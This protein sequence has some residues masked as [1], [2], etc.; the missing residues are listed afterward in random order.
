MGAG[1]TLLPIEAI[2]SDLTQALRRVK[3]FILEAPTGSGKSTQVPQ[4]LIDEAVVGPGTVMVLQPRRLAARMLA[5]RVAWERQV[6]LGSEVGYQIR[7]DHQAGSATRITYVTEGILLRRMLENPRLDGVAALLFDEFHER[8]IYSDVTLA[9]AFQIQQQLRPDL[10]LGVMSATLETGRLLEFLAPAACLRA[11]G[12]AWPVTISHSAAAAAVADR[13]IWEQVAWHFQK[14]VREHPEGDV[15]VFL[16]GAFE[17]QRT[18][19][20]IQEAVPPRDWVVLPLHGD[21]PPAQ[22]DAALE[23]YPQRKCVVATNVAETSLTIEGIR[24][25]IDSGLAR[26]AAFD[27]NRGINTLLVEKI[28]RASA[29]QR[30]GRA[31]RTAPGHCLRL[32]GPSDHQHRAAHETPEIRRLD[33]SEIALT[34]KAGGVHDLESFPW[35]EA[36]APSSLSRALGLL[37]E[38]GALSPAGTLTDVGMRMA[39]FPLH[40]RYARMLIEA[41]SRRCVRT[42]AWVAALSQVRSLLLPL[43]DRSRAAAREATLHDPS[44]ESSD[45]FVLLRAW[46][47]AAR[48]NFA[49]DH[50]RQWGIHSVSARQVGYIADQL[51]HLAKSQGLDLDEE[52]VSLDE[53]RRCILLGFSDQLARRLDRATY[54]CQMVHG[55]KGEVRPHSAVTEAPLLV[56]GEVE[57]RDLRGEISVWLSLN[58]A[59]EEAWLEECFPSEMR[60]R[61]AVAFDALQRRVV[62]RR[63]RVFRDLVLE[64]KESDDVPMDDAARILAD[65]VLAGRLILKAWNAEAERWIGRINFAAHHC[66]DYGYHPIGQSERRLILEQVCHGAL[67]YREIKDREVLPTLLD[68]VP[69]NLRP[70]LDSIAPPAISLPRGQKARLRYEAD[71]KAILSATVQQLFDAPDRF[72]LADGRAVAVIEILAPNRRPVQVTSDLGSFWAHS[73]AEVRKQLRGRYPKHEWR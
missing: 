18:V 33:L 42:V 47:L 53:V 4:M 57:E 28:S 3:R 17:I 34:L 45:F 7:F 71:G 58:T 62:C 13:P 12:R 30:A 1:S 40:P 41:S 10:V 43:S 20:A 67:A 46:Q 59:V 22:Q 36:P 37:R 16:P 21:L 24:L 31:G 72:P 38:L 26:K 64:T 9:R 61:T 2:R 25:V 52:S 29:D 32:W 6:P 63:E 49:L 48:G 11:E 69:P 14:L 73:Y 5:R 68:W 15:L 44:G 39:T 70:L 55:R 60:A 51:L 56:S 19:A 8:H 35:F 66:P 54:R 50:C 27:P 65:E 23:R